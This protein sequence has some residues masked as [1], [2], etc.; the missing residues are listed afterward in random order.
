MTYIC[1]TDETGKLLDVVA[2]RDLLLARP[3]QTLADIMARES[4]VF[5]PDIRLPEAVNSAFVVGMLED[6]IARIVALAVFLPVLAGQS[7][8]TGCQAPAITLRS[9]TLGELANVSMAKLRPQSA[10]SFYLDGC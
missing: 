8:N 4:F 6:T 2:M 3:G 9:L 5:T 7:G 10:C 1:V